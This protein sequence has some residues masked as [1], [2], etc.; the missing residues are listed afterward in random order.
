M[1]H[2]VTHAFLPKHNL[3]RIETE[4]GR[5]YQTPLGNY[6]SVT[7]ALGA[8]DHGFVDAWRQAVGEEEANNVGRRAAARGT[9]LHENA[10]K[11]LLN[12]EVKTSNFLDKDLYGQIVPE[13]KNI[14]DIYALEYPL[15]S[16]TL[17]LAGTVDCIAKY[18]GEYC[19]IDFKTSG[20]VK[21]QHEIDSYFIQ[22]SLYSLMFEEMYGIKI[23]KLC[24]IMAIEFMKPKVFH[25]IRADWFP[26]IG[27]MLKK[28]KSNPGYNTIL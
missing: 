7:T 8:L 16:D 4:F 26:K 22:T 24:I 20:R 6:M 5:K 2:I 15:Y 1:K 27:A 10:E 21:D 3:P 13:L 17:K 28:L 12:Q 19:I 18:K 11:F 14:S 9:T 23:Q 25:G